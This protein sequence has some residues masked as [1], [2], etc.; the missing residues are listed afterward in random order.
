MKAFGNE[1]WELIDQGAATFVCGN[2]TTIAPAVRATLLEIFRGESGGSAQDAEVWFA[3][4]RAT[5]R[6]VEDIW[7]G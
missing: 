3:D 5:D 6:F 1:I 7:G 4:L 2:A